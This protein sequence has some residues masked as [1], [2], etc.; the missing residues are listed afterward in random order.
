MKKFILKNMM[1]VFVL[2][3]ATHV[4][5]QRADSSTY[6][7]AKDYLKA[8]EETDPNMHRSRGDRTIKLGNNLGNLDTTK[9]LDKKACCSKKKKAGL[10]KRK[11][12]PKNLNLP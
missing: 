11:S 10:A 5:A 7:S 4:Y 2:L 8:R 3:T 12:Q 6:K 9:K 1:L